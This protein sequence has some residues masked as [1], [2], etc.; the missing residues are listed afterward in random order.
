M[1]ATVS[2][3]AE[4]TR[5][6]RRVALNSGLLLAAYGFQAVVSIVIVGLVARYL[7]QAGL[8]RYGFAISFIELFIAF[9]DLGMNRILVREISRDLKGAD[10]YTSVIWTLRLLLS[11]LVIVIVGVAAWGNGDSQLWWAIMVYLLAQVLFLLGDVFNS[12][13][14]GF[15]RMEYQFW[16]VNLSQV[17]L[18]GLTVAVIWLDWGL[19]ALFGARLV[20][21][22]IK[23]VYVWWVSRRRFA[24]ARFLAGLLPGAWQSLR[25][26]PR[27][28]QIVRRE[29]RKQA[30]AYLKAQGRQW[31]ERWQQ[32][33]LAWYMLVESVP[34][35]IS[36]VLRSYIWRGGVVLTV[37]WLGQ[38]QGD[39]VNGLLYG[40]LRVVQQMRIVPTSIAAAMLPVFSNRAVNRLDEFDSAFAKSIKLFTAISVLIALAFTLLARPM[41]TLLLGRNIDLVGAA[42]VLALLGWVSVI[43]FPN[44]LYGVTLAALGR[45]R[46]ETLG[47]ALGLA[48]GYL[49]ARWAVPR[50]EA[51]GVAAAVLVAEG[52]FFVVGTVAMWQHFRWRTLL[53]SLGKITLACAAAGLVFG[54]TDQVWLRLGAANSGLGS[55]V[56]A[57]IELIVAGGLGLVAFGAALWLLRT[58]DR[59]EQEAIK[60]MLRLRGGRS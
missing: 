55:A 27:V 5:P 8:G 12:V 18:L 16:G 53:P 15:Q 30:R 26:L 14:H 41:V 39:L 9:I 2:P 43:Y 46:M 13:F 49:L 54:L 17:L 37:L 60:A 33:R 57:L 35:G 11:M 52:A 24:R 59:D 20:A 51:L 10:R 19:V 21:N 6:E 38:Q 44:W 7:G 22:G 36:L 1:S 4:V 31:G 32:A 25:S 3:A 45:Q 28:W 48:S 56:S 29:G 58:F 40:P 50:W 23:L 47:L 42:Q 34:V